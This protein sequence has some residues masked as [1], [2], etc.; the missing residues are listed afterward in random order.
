MYLRNN[1]RLILLAAVA[2]L[3]FASIMV[4]QS[5]RQSAQQRARPKPQ[6]QV[7]IGGGGDRVARD[8][9][10]GTCGSTNNVVAVTNGVETTIK[11]PKNEGDCAFTL[12][13]RD[14]A[15][16]TV[17]ETAT[18]KKDGMLVSFSCGKDAV[19]IGMD[20]AEGGT[21]CVLSFGGS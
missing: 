4:A 11:S 14:K 9:L 19:T 2:L 10:K 7:L 3:S 20:C 6:D 15:K 12:R 18:I 8:T 21:N 5:Q 13:C 17:G 1:F 16:N